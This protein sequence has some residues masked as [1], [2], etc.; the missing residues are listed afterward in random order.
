[1]KYR[2]VISD[3]SR[4]C[5][6]FSKGRLSSYPHPMTAQELLN[7][8]LRRYPFTELQDYVDKPFNFDSEGEI[9]GGRELTEREK[10][11]AAY[12]ILRHDGHIVG[13]FED[14]EAGGREAAEFIRT[15]DPREGRGLDYELDCLENN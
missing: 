2:L 11:N 5:S 9:V 12:E 10:V 6:Y 1:M 4:N 13:I 15:Q 8:A 14:T 3:Y 7:E